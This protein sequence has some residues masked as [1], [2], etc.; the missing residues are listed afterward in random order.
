MKNL[1]KK[2][3][4]VWWAHLHGLA[5]LAQ[6]GSFT[7]AAERLGISKAAMSQRMAEL[8]GAVG[9]PLIQRTT[10]SVRLTELGLQL[11]ADTRD[12]FEHIAQTFVQAKDAA[13]EPR[14]LIR[15]TAPVALARQQLVP[16]LPAFL[17]QHPGVRI[18]LD[19]SDRITSMA[20]EGFD[21]AIRH[22]SSAPDTHVARLLCNTR[23]ILVASPSFV[24]T[25][26]QPRQPSELSRLPCL[27]YP[28]P[29]SNPVWTFERMAKRPS[30]HPASVQV[31]GPFS[32]NNSE[33]LRDA[34]IAG[35]GVALLPDFSVQA[36][37]QAGQLLRLLPQW[38]AVGVFAPSIYAVRPYAPHV[39][40][41]L[42][43][44]IE[45]LRRSFKGGFGPT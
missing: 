37:I 6:H 40:R 29:Q 14:G 18:Q 13:G 41:A 12:A 19:L 27:N 22:V 9:A 24:Q 7:A 35:L 25:H 21:L 30:S 43:L 36:A 39:P 1:D 8:E 5:M 26:G 32:A 28:R 11:V 3:D 4:G 2:Q 10:R 38:H 33:A 20:A 15:V 42:G 34:A 17:Q 31:S 16:R 44:L 23:T 45:H